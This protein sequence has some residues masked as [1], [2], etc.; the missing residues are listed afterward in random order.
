MTAGDRP[1][2]V[3]AMLTYAPGSLRKILVLLVRQEVINKT[4][5]LDLASI[6]LLI[7]RKAVGYDWVKYHSADPGM[8]LGP[9]PWIARLKVADQLIRLHRCGWRMLSWDLSEKF[10]QSVPAAYNMNPAYRTKLPTLFPEA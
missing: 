3:F 6:I 5:P 8:G 1:Y 9:A 7:P 2:E 10:W 4:I